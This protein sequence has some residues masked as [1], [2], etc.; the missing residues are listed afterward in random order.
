MVLM[1]DS[2]VRKIIDKPGK[3][4]ARTSCGQVLG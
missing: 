4:R 3:L 1:S 2:E